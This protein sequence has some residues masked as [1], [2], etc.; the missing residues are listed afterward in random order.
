MKKLLNYL[1]IGLV[2]TFIISSCVDNKFD[3]PEFPFEDPAIN[4]NTTIAGIKAL[5]SSGGFE[6]IT[7]DLVFSAIVIANDST[8]NFYKKIVVQDETGGLEI[9][10][11]GRDLYGKYPVGRKVFVKAK[12]LVVGDDYGIVQLGALLSDG[13]LVS[14]PFQQVGDIVVGGSLNNPITAKELSFSQVTDNDLS[15]LVKFNDVEFS[16][17]ELGSTFADGTAH[18]DKNRIL[19]DCS[20]KEFI[21]RTSGYAEFANDTLPSLKGSLMCVVGKYRSDYQGYLRSLNDINFDQER[22]SGGGTGDIAFNKDFEDLDIYSGGWT[23]QVVVGTF[24]W[25]ASEYSGDRFGKISNYNGSSHVASEAWLISPKTDVSGYSNPAFTFRNTCNYDGAVLEIYVTDN[26]DGTSKPNVSQWK[27]L[28]AN[29]SSG[30]WSWEDSGEI[31][32]SDYSGKEIYVAFRYTGTDSDGKTWEIDDIILKEGSGSGGA[33]AF[34]DDF[35]GGIDKWNAVNVLGDQVWTHSPQYGNP[36]GCAKMTGFSGSSNANEDWLVTPQ[37][38]FS[39]ISSPSLTFD[40]ATKYDG[41]AMEVYISTDYSG[42]GDP[43]AASWTKLDYV[44]S[45]GNWAWASSGKIDL[46]SYADQKVFIG[47]KY[48][49]TDS[50]SATWEIDNV[51][52]K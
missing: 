21:I 50:A 37:I 47:F 39:G 30:N 18:V 6:T 20:K 28:N 13:A 36:G 48:T 38:D 41:N 26:Y 33:S 45:G 16:S 44:Q 27:K 2:S 31:S 51:V 12:D 35:E 14:I 7:D 22:C 34:S 24:N 15:T 52:V 11:D 1:L 25:E 32:L 46:S 49:S 3:E 29:L 4:T 43:N 5:H 8:G 42:A 23:T 10:I 17:S 40:N 19:E 9:L